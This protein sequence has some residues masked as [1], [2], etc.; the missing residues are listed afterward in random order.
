MKYITALAL[1][2]TFANCLSAAE[3][4]P[5]RLLRSNR[6]AV[7]GCS[8]CLGV[9]ESPHYLPCKHVFCTACIT[10]WVAAHNSCPACRASVIKT[11]SRLNRKAIN[12]AVGQVAVA[13]EQ[14][15]IIVSNRQTQAQ[16]EY[17]TQIIQ[18]YEAAQLAV[19]KKLEE[20]KQRA[21]AFCCYFRID[22][23]DPGTRCDI[24]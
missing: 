8:I 2:I 9:I 10:P 4:K 24:Q 18:Q 17:L 1:L 5:I 23:A 22:Q 20:G 15:R 6:S 14:S 13:V 3:Q 7:P 21:A 11:N 12:P 16:D 19:Q